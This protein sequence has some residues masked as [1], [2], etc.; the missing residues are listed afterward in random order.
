MNQQKENL[1]EK[2][3]LVVA[4]SALK[5]VDRGA[6]ANAEFLKA[7]R[8]VDNQT[9]QVFNRSLKKISEGK[10]HPDFVDANTA[11]Q[12]GFSAEVLVT[13]KNNAKYILKESTVRESR[14][15]DVAAYGKNHKIVDRVKLQ[16]GKIIS[17]TEAQ[18]KFVAKPENLIDK[19]V[20]G[21]GGGKND[22]SRYQDVII[23]L[24]SEQV[25]LVKEYCAAKAQSLRDQADSLEKIGSTAKA[26]E[27]RSNA[28]T[29]EKVSGN[30]ADAGITSEQ[31]IYARTHPKTTIAVEIVKTSHHA[32]VQSLKYGA[33]VGGSVSVFKNSFALAQK[34]KSLGSALVDVSIDTTKAAALAYG[35]T[36]VGS[37][38]KS[39]MQQ[40]GSNI[41]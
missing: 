22:F 40:S 3:R 28:N 36:F 26:K 5:T 16:N 24:P 4:L 35:T 27:Y 18:M 1:K 31:A 9:G 19:I 41:V 13:S 17:G 12:A 15:E 25:E 29:Y 37:T 2:E 39:V 11:Q 7:Y 6:N 8:G 14:S 21:A 32:G 10:I 33:V 23:E 20:T 38:V 30:C 34:Q